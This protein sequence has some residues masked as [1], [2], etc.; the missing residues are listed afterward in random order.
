MSSMNE[1]LKGGVEMKMPPI[2]SPQERES[3][4]EKLAGQGEGADLCPRCA[5]RRAP[6]DA[7]DGRGWPWMAVEKDYRFGGP[8]G[9]ASLLDV[10]DWPES[11]CRGAHST[12]E[13][14]AQVGRPPLKSRS[15][16]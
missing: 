8:N 6:A 11:G 5:G 12:I 14:V 10:A 7:V 13:P 2:V 1:Y 3:A 16:A 9:L 4:R 15:S